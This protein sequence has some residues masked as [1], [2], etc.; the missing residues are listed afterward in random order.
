LGDLAGLMQR[1]GYELPVVDVEDLRLAYADPLL[2]LRE[3]RAAGESNAVALRDRRV[4]GRALFPMALGALGGE[5]RV[6]VLLRVGT[7]TGWAPGG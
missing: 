1:A 7:V 5:A 2:L 3:L 6:E 4:P